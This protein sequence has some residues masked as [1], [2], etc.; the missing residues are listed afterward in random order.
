MQHLGA[1]KLNQAGDTLSVYWADI[2]KRQHTPTKLLG[3]LFD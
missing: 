3:H 1:P 2:C